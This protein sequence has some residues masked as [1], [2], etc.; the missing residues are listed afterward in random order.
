MVFGA[1]IIFGTS[2]SGLV[3]L[4]MLKAW[5]DRRGV[6]IVPGVR[7]ALDVYAL[8]ARAFLVSFDEWIAHL[9]SRSVLY[10]RF[11]VHVTAMSFAR[12][13]RAAERGAHRIAD[14]VSLKHRF[15]RRETQS[16]FLKKVSEHKSGLDSISQVQ[17]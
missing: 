2:L 8:E 11:F 3:A 12:V 15:E 7:N 6:T 9:P 14:R 5:E 16:D 1:T 4:F 17:K 13:A 10:A